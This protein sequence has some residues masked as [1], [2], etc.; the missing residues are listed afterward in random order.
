MSERADR[1]EKKCQEEEQR[2]KGKTKGGEKTD[3]ECGWL[4]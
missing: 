1:R 3:R 4:Q 2:D